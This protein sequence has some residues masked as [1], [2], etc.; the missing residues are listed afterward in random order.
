M[1]TRAEIATVREPI[2]YATGVGVLRKEA[3]GGNYY[4]RRRIMTDAS[5]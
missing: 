2:N 1:P 5:E 3:N 4:Q